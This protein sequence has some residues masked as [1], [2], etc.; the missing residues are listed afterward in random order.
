MSHQAA[1]VGNF[2]AAVPLKRDAL[3]L[4]HGGTYEPYPVIAR[5]CVGIEVGWR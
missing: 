2:E 5:F 4:D 3:M 1:L